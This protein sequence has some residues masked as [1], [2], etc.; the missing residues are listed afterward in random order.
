MNDL[1][2]SVASINARMADTA[3]PMILEQLQAGARLERPAKLR[4]YYTTG[5]PDL[6]CRC[7]P[8]ARVKKLEREGVLQRI[9]VDTY[10]L[11][12][13]YKPEPVA[14]PRLSADD[15][16]LDLFGGAAA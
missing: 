4:D 8:A 10:G 13:G 2:E 6:Y 1:G 16:Q 15:E 14:A 9:G 5:L 12:P 11:V 7:L 3:W